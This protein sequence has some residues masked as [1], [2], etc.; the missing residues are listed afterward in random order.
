MDA[1]RS[2]SGIIDAKT[3]IQKAEVYLLA[4]PGTELPEAELRTTIE[5]DFGYGLRAYERTT[6]AEWK[7]LGSK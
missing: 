1:L 5:K 6:D 2:R 4:E 7:Q 3:D